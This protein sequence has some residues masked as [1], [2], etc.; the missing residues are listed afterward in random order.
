MSVAS[1][2]KLPATERFSLVRIRP[3]RW[4]TSGL[5]SLG[6]NLYRYSYGFAIAFSS[7]QKNGTT[8]GLTRVYTTPAS[9]GQYQVNEDA[10]TITIYL[11]LAPNVSTDHYVAFIYL[12]Y[13]EREHR[14][15]T[16]NPSDSATTGRK[17]IPRLMAAPE[18]TQSLKNIRQGLLT[19]DD[20]QIQV[21]NTDAALQAY[22]TANDSFYNAE[23]IIWRA[24][25][26]T[27][28]L[29]RWFTGKIS[30]VSGSR[31]DVTFGAFETLYAMNQPADLGQGP[32]SYTWLDSSIYPGHFGRPRHLSLGKS[33]WYETAD[34]DNGGYGPARILS[35]ALKGVSLS[36]TNSISVNANRSWGLGQVRGALPT[37]SFG[38]IQACPG[39]NNG[40][41]LNIR[42]ASYSNLYIGDTFKFTYGGNTGYG[43]IC[44]VGN[45]SYEGTAY[46]VCVWFAGLAYNAYTAYWNNAA[47][48]VP[49]KC[50]G[51]WLTG[52]ASSGI[53]VPLCLG[54][55]FSLTE[56]VDAVSSNRQLAV[57]LANSAEGWYG[58]AAL[59]P[60]KHD[61]I[62]RVSSDA[63]LTHGTIA[64]LL[65]EKAGLTV[66]AASIT[67][68]NAALTDTVN[69]SIPNVDETELGSY[70]QYLGELLRSVLG[71]IAVNASGEIEYR[72]LAAPSSTA[73]RD[74]DLLVLGSTSFQV[75]YQDVRHGLRY[76]NPHLPGGSSAAIVADDY[77]DRAKYLYGV[78]ESDEYRH[79]LDLTGSTISR[80]TQIQA[81]VSRPRTVYQLATAT[82]DID[83]TL[84]D[85]V[86]LQSKIVLGG[87]ASRAVKVITLTK[88][89]ST[90]A[91]EAEDLEG[92]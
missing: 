40:G 92:L 44:W 63:T 79:C 25:T 36:Y 7:L 77:S 3:C 57:T 53:P 80:H 51:V 90:V 41:F 6:S 48:I 8:S 19:F 67:A 35:D 72:L 27:T 78:T 62:Y 81:V 29:Q 5:V 33:S 58:T 73:V 85:D 71:Y 46:N 75:D 32:G 61:M 15:V 39:I 55:D 45:Y 50:I 69:F 42:F 74:S 30:S 86:L 65:L 84:G 16:E 34:Y 12:F 21:A 43:T 64:Q 2:K 20:T 49:Q 68:A 88:Q 56:T 47:T 83:T 87:T 38:A 52:L 76:R 10:G 37:Q 1:E 28:N 82:E 4:L 24:I 66:N 70:A 13:T 31:T 59:D 89:A 18:V 17:W 23:V 9:N 91:A 11:T 54:R 22:M 60:N 14:Y 26:S